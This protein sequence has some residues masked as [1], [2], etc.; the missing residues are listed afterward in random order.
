MGIYNHSTCDRYIYTISVM[1]L[2]FLFLLLI[3]HFWFIAEYQYMSRSN[4]FEIFI[5]PLLYYRGRSCSVWFSRPAILSF[6]L[7]MASLASSGC[8]WAY[9]RPL[10][11]DVWVDFEGL[12]TKHYTTVVMLIWSPNR[13]RCLPLGSFHDTLNDIMKP[14]NKPPTVCFVSWLHFIFAV[15]RFAYNFFLEIW[16]LSEPGSLA[17]AKICAVSVLN[18]CSGR[19]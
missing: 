10:R 5:C 13:V 3:S 18:S 6:N 9:V 2:V 12:P 1:L 15:W 8:L 4:C 11:E 17:M 14:S 19:F 7:L 16:I